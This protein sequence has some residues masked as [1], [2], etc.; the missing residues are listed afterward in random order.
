VVRGGN[1]NNPEHHLTRRRAILDPLQFLDALGFR[2]AS[3]KAP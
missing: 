3:D 2:T 1:W